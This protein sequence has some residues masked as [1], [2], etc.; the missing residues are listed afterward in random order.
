MPFA[1]GENKPKTR[2]LIF[3]LKNHLFNT[4][5]NL[6]TMLKLKNSRLQTLRLNYLIIK[7]LTQQNQKKKVLKLYL[8]I[9]FELKICFFAFGRFAP[10]FV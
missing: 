6:C 7:L 2:I 4:F 1:H 3:R 5:L 10:T 9:K 8:S